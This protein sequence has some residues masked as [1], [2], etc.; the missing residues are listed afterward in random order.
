MVNCS[1]VATPNA[2]EIL[3]AL[4]GNLCH[5][6]CGCSDS[7]FGSGRC[8]QI[9]AV[10]MMRQMSDEIKRLCGELERIATSHLAEGKELRKIAWDAVLATPQS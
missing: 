1:P 3:E 6:N 8:I 10:E 9:L 7:D 5:E 4:A 2:S